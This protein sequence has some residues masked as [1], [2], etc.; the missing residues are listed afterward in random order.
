LKE[1]QVDAL[2]SLTASGP[3]F[4]FTMIE[5]MIDAGVLMGFQAKEA[6]DL[7]LQMLQGCVTL[8]Q[9]TERHPGELKWQIASPS[10]TTIAGIRV[11]EKENVR[12]GIIETFLATYQKTQEIAKNHEIKKPS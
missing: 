12:S 4:V 8:L 5:A 9:Q 3:A 1:S 2:T 7:I 6:Q 11:L 10:G